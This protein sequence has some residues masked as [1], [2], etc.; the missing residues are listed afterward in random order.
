MAEWEGNGMSDVHPI[1]DADR[2]KRDIDE[3][4]NSDSEDALL[5]SEC[6]MLID[7]ERARAEKAEAAMPDDKLIED[8]ARA[9]ADVEARKTKGVLG[10]HP[11]DGV[12]ADEVLRLYGDQARAAIAVVERHRWQPIETAPT[13]PNVHYLAT[14]G[15]KRWIEHADPRGK[16]PAIRQW[17]NEPKPTHWMPLPDPPTD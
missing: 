5:L 7:Q 15:H 2:I 12:P 1:L 11:V 9:I 10:I 13:D 14:D 17:L 6:A 8:L 16:D 4:I 3:A